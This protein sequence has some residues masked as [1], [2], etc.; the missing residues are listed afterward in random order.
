MASY[1]ATA[2]SPGL[3]MVGSIAERRLALVTW[4]SAGDCRGTLGHRRH[5]CTT[6]RSQQDGCLPW[7]T[8]ARVRKWPRRVLCQ[9]SQRL[10]RHRRAACQVS[11]GQAF[12]RTR[13]VEHA[14]GLAHE[15]RPNALSLARPVARIKSQWG[16]PGTSSASSS[17]WPST[18]QKQTARISKPPR[19][20]RA[21][22]REGSPRRVRLDGRRRAPAEK[23]IRP[24]L[25]G[26]D[27]SGNVRRL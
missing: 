14:E 2:P 27:C 7:P 6:S 8:L 3:P 1:D 24:G 19:S 22:P 4:P 15:R 16:P 13:A 25:G 12:P 9:G 11:S 23:C 10:R 17:S 20:P 26:L 18:S 5:T 21:D